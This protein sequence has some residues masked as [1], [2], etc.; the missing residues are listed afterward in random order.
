MHLVRHQQVAICDQKVK[1]NERKQKDAE[2]E[3]H[4]ETVHI[5]T[6]KSFAPNSDL[7][8]RGQDQKYQKVQVLKGMHHLLKIQR[9]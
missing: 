1:S 6:E 4:A 8:G 7:E 5:L 9:M 3:R 2:R